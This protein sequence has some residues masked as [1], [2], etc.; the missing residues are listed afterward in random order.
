MVY[1]QLLRLSEKFADYSAGYLRKPVGKFSIDERILMQNNIFPLQLIKGKRITS[2]LGQGKFSNTYCVVYKGKEMV[3]KL[4][5]DKA[6][7]EGPTKL[8]EIK[9]FVPAKFKK[10]IMTIFDQ[11]HDPE[12]GVYVILAELLEPLNAHVCNTITGKNTKSILYPLIDL[13]LINKTVENLFGWKNPEEFKE[14]LGLKFSIFVRKLTEVVLNIFKTYE[15]KRK[16][17]SIIEKMSSK[18][19]VELNNI[20]TDRQ[21]SKLYNENKQ[22]IDSFLY[23]IDLAFYG[24][25]TK[26]F[27]KEMNFPRDITQY[28][29]SVYRYGFDPFEHIPETKSLMEFL[30]YLKQVFGIEFYD[31]HRYNLMQRPKTKDIVISDPGLFEIV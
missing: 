21:F 18:F 19:L 7:V 10:H 25:L 12:N 3:A 26:I 30:K 28:D 4:T 5:T 22:K 6:S 8:F 27:D 1:N 15:N 17:N 9:K 31:L 11:F 13:G 16:T 24:F 2:H 20:F 14:L 29:E 23:K